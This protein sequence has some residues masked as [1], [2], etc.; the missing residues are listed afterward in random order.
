ML[1]LPE[2]KLLLKLEFKKNLTSFFHIVEKN[3]TFLT[4]VN[5][6]KMARMINLSLRIVLKCEKLAD[7]IFCRPSKMCVLA[8]IKFRGRSMYFLWVH[9]KI[10]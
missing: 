2:S 6:F 8:S 7:I 5:I 3:F 1:R 10:T 9:S 4:E